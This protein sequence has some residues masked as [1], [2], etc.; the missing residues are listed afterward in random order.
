MIQFKKINIKINHIR[1]KFNF[2]QILNHFFLEYDT[3]WKNRRV[4]G[5]IIKLLSLKSAQD[6]ENAIILHVGKNEFIL[7][8]FERDILK[9]YII[10]S[11]DNIDVETLKVLDLLLINVIV[12]KRNKKTQKK[13]RKRNLKKKIY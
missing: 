9:K 11:L 5:R 12:S 7:P 10:K 13:K 3:D 4:T 8:K 1:T 6:I 2:T